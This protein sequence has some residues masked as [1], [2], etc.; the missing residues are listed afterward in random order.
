MSKK[1]IHTGKQTDNVLFNELSRLIE[2]SQRQFVSVANSTLTILFWQIGH[3][4]NE[5][6]LQNKR[7][8]YG[9]KIVVTLS[10]QLEAKYGSNFEEKNLRRMLQF[11]TEFPDWE[12]V[13]TLSRQLSWSHFLAL[14]PIKNKAT[15]LFYAEKAGAEMW[16]IRELRKNIAEKVFE[17]TNIAKMQLHDG[18]TNNLN[19][20]KDPYFFNFLGLK[21]EYLEKD[22]EAA[23]LRQ[24]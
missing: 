23:I 1:T 17:R 5:N 4:I 8:D 20:F 14:I 19:V 12:I 15:K 3:R 18:D 9:K 13:V 2:E 24:L 11:N 6:I 7:A 16:G 21:D 10:R 22:L